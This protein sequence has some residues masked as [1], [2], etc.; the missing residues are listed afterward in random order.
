M[1]WKTVYCTKEHTGSEEDYAIY[2]EALNHATA[3]ICNSKRSYE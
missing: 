1:I 2:K 3:E